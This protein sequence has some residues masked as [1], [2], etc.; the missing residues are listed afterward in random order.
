MRLNRLIL[1]LLILGCLAHTTVVRAH[2]SDMYFQTIRVEVSPRGIVIDWTIKPGPL[3][4]NWVWSGAD[5]NGNNVVDPDELE[6]WGNSHAAL[7]T[8]KLDS[9]ILSWQL[10]ET[11]FPS[12]LNALQSGAESIRLS[13]TAEWEPGSAGDHTLLIANHFEERISINWFYVV[14]MDGMA[15]AAPNQ[16]GKELTFNWSDNASDT[17]NLLTEWDS[18]K[19]TL[20][21]GQKKDVVSE[22]AEQIIPELQQETS[23]DILTNLVKQEELSVRFYVFALGI[24]IA[25]G[26]LHALTPGHG[27]T[28]VAAYLVG[29]RGTA[30]HAIALGTIVTLTHTG[31][32]L[33]LGVIT[34][35][36]SR[37]FLPSSL[38]P[39][40]EIVSGLLIVGLGI[41]LFTRRWRAWRKGHHEHDHVHHHNEPHDHFHE[42]GHTHHTRE[43]ADID[44]FN[45]RS[46]IALGISGGLVPCPD[47]V[48]I[49]LVAIAINR[50]L[51]GLALILAFSFGLALILIVIGLAMV[52]GSRLFARMDFFNRVAPILPMVSAGAVLILGLALTLGAVSKT[53]SPARFE[54]TG[55]A[56]TSESEA[57]YLYLGLDEG[58]VGQIMSGNTRGD[59]SE[60][61]QGASNVSEFDLSP[62]GS[63]LVYITSRLDS[64]KWISKIWM[65][66]L[67]AKEPVQMS[68][69]AGGLCSR[70]Q[71]SPDGGRILFEKMILRASENAVN[72]PTLEW[73][74][75]DTGETLN[76][77]QDEGLPG[78]DANWSPSGEW[79]AYR[80][81]GGEIHL[82]NLLTGET[83]IIATAVA[84][85]IVWPPDSSGF[86]FNNGTVVDDKFITRLFFY[87]LQ[88]GETRMLGDEGHWEDTLSAWSPD[89]SKIAFIRRDLSQ[90]IG[91]QIWMMHADGSD[92]AQLTNST[93]AIHDWLDWSPDGKFLLAQEYSMDQLLSEPQIL[94]IELGSGELKAIGQGSR[95]T[96]W[97]TNE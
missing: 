66:D 19:L 71:W 9:T 94:L 60:L 13:L 30:R 46:L 72:L 65:L 77:F 45:W 57:Q 50:I 32:V 36:A 38:I 93:R 76:V 79:L 11:R 88:S 56:S 20:P 80:S 1:V 18:G 43:F 59:V 14:A 42:H 97:T 68:D 70:V 12:D 28:V 86:L 83:R 44:Q 49:L 51:L 84:G 61:T 25:L 62:D 85:T 58:G 74:D 27:K 75:W 78:Y 95:P 55:P 31:S 39:V 35:I 10:A 40:L 81:A 7:L 23:Q 53:K 34:L 64:G 2:P 33:L 41:N 69:C 63:R 91:E 29:S 48:A 67:T 5:E 26:A 82:Q 92:A 37:Y 17:S 3:L 52:H 16:N 73:M 15:F 21:A 4:A 90:P 8:A 54:Q 89:G 47:A 96:W 87:D 22:T 6:A 24:S